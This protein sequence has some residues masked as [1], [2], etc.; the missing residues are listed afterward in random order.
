MRRGDGDVRTRTTRGAATGDV[1][2][3]VVAPL[4]ISQEIAGRDS[5]EG[6]AVC[7]NNLTDLTA[8]RARAGA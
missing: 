8:I 6:L 4:P 2:P 5:G 7:A 1:A 3:T